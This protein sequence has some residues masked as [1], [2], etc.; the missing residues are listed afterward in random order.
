MKN[1]KLSGIAARLFRAAYPKEDSDV[2]I[3]LS[4][5]SEPPRLK[6]KLNPSTYHGGFTH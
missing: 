1:E 6:N 3:S 5:R 4:A 2:A